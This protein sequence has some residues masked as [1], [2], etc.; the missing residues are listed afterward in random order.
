MSERFETSKDVEWLKQLYFSHELSTIVLE[1]GQTL[2]KEGTFND[3][4]YLI[5]EGTL[6]GYLEDE[7]G[8]LFEVYKSTKNMFV[9]VYSFFSPDNLSYLTV[10]A[11]ERT[12]VAFVEQ[13]QRENAGEKFAAHFLPVIVHEIYLRQ[14][15]TQ[16]LTRQ[17]QAAFKKLYENEKMA[18]LGQLAAGLAHELNNA[19]GVLQRNTEWIIESFRHF[20]KNKS[21]DNIFETSLNHGLSFDTSTLRKRRKALQENLDL[22]P[23]LARQ[24]ARTNLTEARISGLLKENPGALETISLITETGFVLYDMRVAAGHSTHVVQ[25]VR[26]LGF[27]AVGNFTP[28]LLHETITKSLALVKSMLSSINVEVKTISDGRVNANPGD[29]VQVWVNLI[30]NALES[31]ESGG[32]SNPQLTIEIN[33]VNGLYKVSVGDNGPGIPREMI[34]KIF[35]PNFTTKV[36]GLSF[37][38]GLGLSIVKKIIS[39][40]K[41]TVS[42][43]SVPGETFF[44]VF[45]PGHAEN[46]EHL[47]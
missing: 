39:N 44:H 45:L 16:Q 47:T 9:G 24:V 15:L 18:I 20:L 10:V 19:I 23:K 29:L 38:L 46:Q 37:G 22:P 21:F 30:K 13:E 42:V 40:Y 2:L 36:K 26:E 25:S 3:K 17:R 5:L 11:E 41:G 35:E 31:M 33:K 14:V 1:K 7:N 4:L 27:S 8:E 12:V 6:S 43:S 32:T 34:D 28:I